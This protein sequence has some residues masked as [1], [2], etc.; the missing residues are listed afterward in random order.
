M[1]KEE[2]LTELRRGKDFEMDSSFDL[3]AVRV[4][5]EAID[6]V[7]QLP[8]H[9]AEMR[10][11]QMRHQEEMVKLALDYEQRIREIVIDGGMAQPFSMRIMEGY[12]FVVVHQMSVK[13]FYMEVRSPICHRGDA[14][15]QKWRV[16]FKPHEQRG[17]EF[18]PAKYEAE[19]DTL[20]D[21]IALAVAE[22]EKGARAG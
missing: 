17:T 1:N 2:V 6:L 13:G 21:A 3:N 7:E 16:G 15:L 14:C 8:D 12:F 22:V 5:D 10:A 11:M 20:H 4:Y 9:K 19:A 18:P